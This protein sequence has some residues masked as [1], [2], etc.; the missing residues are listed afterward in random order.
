MTAATLVSIAVTPA[1]PDI[2][3]GTTQQ[4]TATGPYTDASTQ[5]VSATVT[6]ASTST[7]VA[8]VSDTLGSNGLATTAGVGITTVSASQGR[9]DRRHHVDRDPRLPFGG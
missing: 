9:S 5:D 1:N 8:T 3:N 7:T 2:A 6:W 4:F